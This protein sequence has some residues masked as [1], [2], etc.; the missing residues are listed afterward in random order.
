MNLVYVLPFSICKRRNSSRTVTFGLEI[1]NIYN[2]Q[3]GLRVRGAEMLGASGS[4]S[5]TLEAG[6]QA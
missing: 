4:L 1:L 5:G 2:E 3:Q 6:G